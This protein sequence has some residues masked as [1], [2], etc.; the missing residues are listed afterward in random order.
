MTAGVL[1]DLLLRSALLIGAVWIA[2]AAIGRAGGSAAARHL[3]W[4][5]GFGGLA[6]L[7]LLSALVPALP[8]PVLPAVSEP[9][10][11]RVLTSH[12]AVVSAAVGGT[13]SGMSIANL[14]LL[15]YAAVAALL[16]LRPV[17]GRILLA[18]MW[19][20]SRLVDDP[21]TLELVDRLARSFGIRR[22]VDVRFAS[23]PAVPMTWGMLRPR[24]LLPA[25]AWRW[26]S[27]QR[28]LV[29]LHELGHI[30]RHDSATW[31]GAA[32]LCAFYWPNPLV[33]LAA[34]RMRR[35]QEHACDDLVLANGAKAETYA[36]SLLGTAR[37]LPPQEPVMIFA[38]AIVRRSDLERRL[39]AIIADLPRKRA[40]AA[41]ATVGAIAALGFTGV[42]A[43]AIP[44]AVANPAPR[45]AVQPLASVVA[46]PPVEP[47]AAPPAVDLQSA[48][49]ES[50]PARIPA[51]TARESISAA[52]APPAEASPE[53]AYKQA[54]ARYRQEKAA[55]E[56]AVAEYRQKRERHRA[57]VDR[58]HRELAE[59]RRLEEAARAL[60]PDDP[61]RHVPPAPVAPV[62]P[63]APPAPVVPPI[64]PD[65]NHS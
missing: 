65:L 40:G 28:R 22:R 17:A 9:S 63:V 58:Y 35:E 42:T 4:L 62:A 24:I 18:Q 30:A 8:L 33:W 49:I 59:H 13:D 10:I 6:L 32:V 39:S 20:D 44:V 5:L 15:A 25:D 21:E 41:F 34:E 14:L 61:A 52:L 46:A 12:G 19:R 51:T 38:A 56:L 43:A 26:S 37:A 7:P 48:P 47:V 45:P 16:L 53:Q 50:S 55:Y 11:D 3:A 2:A 31:M 57:Q 1:I 29:L 23:G 60:P 54:I 36:R 64:P 27:E